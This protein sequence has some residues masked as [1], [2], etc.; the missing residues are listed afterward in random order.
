MP[1]SQHQA[2]S[3]PQV[4][5]YLRHDVTTFLLTAHV[6]W[7][8]HTCTRISLKRPESISGGAQTEASIIPSHWNP[9]VC[10]HWNFRTTTE[11]QDW[12]ST[13]P[14]KNRLL[15]KGAAS[16]PYTQDQFNASRDNI[17]EHLRHAI[18]DTF[19]RDH[20]LWANALQSFAF[21][22]GEEAYDISIPPADKGAGWTLQ[23]HHSSKIVSLC[24]KSLKRLGFINSYVQSF[25]YAY[26]TLTHRA[27]GKSPFNIVLTRELPFIVTFGGLIGAASDMPKIERCTI[28]NVKPEC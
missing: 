12:K 14:Y 6:K 5:T 8:V 17:L 1:P 3:T 2:S 7:F 24:I 23:M 16:D 28:V 21:T 18:W 9:S 25:T 22:R 27:T 13:G 19:K 26:N 20:S 11:D 15:L 10:C 4:G